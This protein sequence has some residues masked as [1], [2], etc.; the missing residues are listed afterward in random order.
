MAAPPH[1]A[2]PTG[3]RSGAAQ[4]SAGS[5]PAA[6]RPPGFPAVERVPP[7]P[8]PSRASNAVNTV[9]SPPASQRAGSPVLRGAAPRNYGNVPLGA[10]HAPTDELLALASCPPFGPS[11]LPSIKARQI[12]RLQLSGARKHARNSAPLLTVPVAPMWHIDR[13]CLTLYRSLCPSADESAA[14][15]AAFERVKA[16]LLDQF[17]DGSVHLFGSLANGLCI[18]QSNDIDVTLHLDD[19]HDMER[20]VKAELVEAL[21]ETLKKE[22][23]LV[24]RCPASL[25]CSSCYIS[26]CGVAA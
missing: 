4:P 20:S 5:A 10:V 14:A 2:V 25:C 1:G 26:H 12:P 7:T 13:T 19:F 24:R 9:S 6:P 22:G 23:M 3:V 15:H 8:P 21:A 11:P 16:V 18:T 17:P